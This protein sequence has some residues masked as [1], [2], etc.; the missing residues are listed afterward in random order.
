MPVIAKDKVIVDP[1]VPIG[2]ATTLWCPV[3]GHPKPTVTWYRGDGMQVVDI[4]G[5]S[6]FIIF[7]SHLI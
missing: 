4:P 1:N 2:H 5:F 6:N 3:S 7:N